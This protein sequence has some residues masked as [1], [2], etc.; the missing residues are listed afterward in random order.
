MNHEKIAVIFDMDGLIIDSEPLW[1]AAEISVFK[2]MGYQFTDA[3]C[4]QTMGMRIDS[5]VK[6]WHKK[7]KWENPSIETVVNNIQNKVIDLVNKQGKPLDGV[8][9]TIDLLKRNNI[10]IA[11]ASSSS[12]K[13]INA[14]VNKLKLKDK[15]D[16]IHS[17]EN[18]KNGKP[19]PAVFNSTASMLKVANSNCIVLEDSKHGMQAA[20]NAEMKV[21]VIP[22]KGTQPTW[23]NKAD[24]QLKSLTDFNLSHLSLLKAD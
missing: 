16:V 2:S 14:V 1:R 10:P 5:V 17:A 21:I 6:F 20:I 23:T 7:Y 11:I 15:F 22:E 12:S 13:I 19:H 4:M 24:L 18:E 8:I 3:M 9:T